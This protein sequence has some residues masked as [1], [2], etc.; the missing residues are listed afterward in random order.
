MTQ[1]EL[2]ATPNPNPGL[3]Q[4]TWAL[5]RR[6]FCHGAWYGS[7]DISDF[8]AGG[9]G[10]GL[11][12]V[13]SRISLRGSALDVEVGITVRDRGSDLCSWSKVGS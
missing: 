11:L 7:Q 13:W 1:H 4:G 9:F 5:L 10:L 8:D 3:T 12:L 6:A 2:K